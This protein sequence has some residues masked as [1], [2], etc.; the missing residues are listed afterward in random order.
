MTGF[1]DEGGGGPVPRLPDRL[2]APREPLWL[3]GPE[4]YFLPALLPWTREL[5]RSENAVL[6]LRGIQVW[7]DSCTLNITVFSTRSLHAPGR[8][9]F[10]HPMAPPAPG[11]FRFGVLFADGRR[12]TN[13]D[14]GPWLPPPTNRDPAG[15]PVLRMGSGGSSGG[16]FHFHTSAGLWPLPP[17]GPLTLVVARQDQGIP[18]TRTE[19][20]GSAIQAAAAGAVE[21]WSDLPPAPPSGDPGV[22]VSWA[23]ASSSAG[24]IAV[25]RRVE[26]EPPEEPESGAEHLGDEEGELE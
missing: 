9:V 21:I 25:A 2:Y 23:H 24:G 4:Q 18:E 5:G 15:D 12:A 1:F 14:R 19:L 22:G 6:A 10:G 8:S 17:D 26:P 7:P 3:S 11:G 16:Q 13:G 20:D